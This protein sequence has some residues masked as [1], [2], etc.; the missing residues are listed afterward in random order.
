[1]IH[2]SPLFAIMFAVGLVLTTATQ[3]RP[4]SSSAG[5]GEL[6]LCGWVILSLMA[7][8]KHRR[9]DP[10]SLP[11]MLAAF[12]LIAL[13]A[14]AAG[15]ILGPP[16]I[17]VPSVI[18]DGQA[19]LFVVL[20]LFALV[21][22][23]GAALRC[24]R[25]VPWVLSLSLVPLFAL[26]VAGLYSSAIGPLDLWYGYRF[27]GWAENPNQ[28]ALLTTPAPFICF[29]LA[30]NPS[31]TPRCWSLTLAGLAVV[32]GL[33][34]CSDALRVAWLASGGMLLVAGW[35]R[36]AMKFASDRRAAVMAL[37]IAPVIVVA[38]GLCLGSSLADIATTFARTTFE[39]GHQGTDRLSAWRNG[40]DII[41]RS[42]LVG[43]GPGT[44]A[45]APLSAET[46]E[47]HNTF[48]DWASNTGLIGLFAYV[49]L[50]GW[51]AATVCRDGNFF[52]AAAIFAL[53]VFSMFGYVVRHPIYWYY[54]IVTVALSGPPK[55][56]AHSARFD[57]DYLPPRIVPR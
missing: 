3:L 31:G 46:L 52:L 30:V 55:V 2:S 53:T 41:A 50:L 22:P 16:P 24:R 47:A 6:L 25:T 57:D 44:H 27:I 29:H 1:M 33:A 19:I 14:L 17:S 54:L 21:V 56:R 45:T 36:S 9:L 26:W 39:A 32:V 13:S 8:V 4:A 28:L 23:S 18:H 34:T 49:V 12:W 42:P 38:T 5:L 37:G 10:S 48:V 11:K 40:A 35:F 7:L 43:R 51:A 20:V 15:F